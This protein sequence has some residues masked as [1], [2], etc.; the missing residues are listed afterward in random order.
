MSASGNENVFIFKLIVLLYFRLPCSETCPP[1]VYDQLMKPCWEYEKERR[2]TFTLIL[3]TVDSI[4]A[5][6]GE[7]V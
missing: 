2:P 4:A 7:A 1:A 6:F 3:K 5:E